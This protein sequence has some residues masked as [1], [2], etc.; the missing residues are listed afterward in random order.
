M[1][2]N[3]ERESHSELFANDFYKKCISIG[4]TLQEVQ[5]LNLLVTKLKGKDTIAEKHGKSHGM[6]LGFL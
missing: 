2:K 1:A 3:Q 4:E 5:K 6:G